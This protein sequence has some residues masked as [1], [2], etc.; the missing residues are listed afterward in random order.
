MKTAEAYG[1][2]LYASSSSTIDANNHVRRDVKN[3]SSGDVVADGRNFFIAVE[4][5]G[6]HLRFVYD[7]GSGPRHLR[8][9]FSQPFSDSRWHD[10]TILRRNVTHVFLRVDNTT[11]SEVLT[12]EANAWLSSE[13]SDVDFYVGGAPEG[14]F[15]ILP[16]LVS[17]WRLQGN[18]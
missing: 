13:D 17:Q 5:S 7:L 12:A 9:G 11:K 16:K 6:G 1:L 3:I 18:V 4:L 10:V 15:S 2:I 8:V 14:M